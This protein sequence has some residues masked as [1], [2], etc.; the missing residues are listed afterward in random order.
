MC[1]EGSEQRADTDSGSAEVVDLIDLQA[2]INLAASGQNLIN[3]ISGN[4]V[5]TA[6]ERVQLNQVKIVACLYIV[7]SCIQTG[8]VHPLVIDTER[9]LERCQMGNRVLRQHAQ[10]VG[11]D[12]IRDTVMD[13]RIDVVRTAGKHDAS[14]AGFFHI[15]KRFL[16]FFLHIASCSAK[17]FPSG[18]NSSTDFIL[19]QTGELFDKT[20]GKH[21]FTRKRKERIAERNG[22]V[23]QLVHVVFDIF[24]IRGNDWAVVVVDGFRELGA[25]VRDTR[26]EDELHT[27]A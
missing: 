4:G 1:T 25:L 22:I 10:S 17:L 19:R 2:G 11:V 5:E 8:V 6:A 23:L 16:A 24:R 7:C 21:L 9:T 15:L 18:M 26:V 27:V 14:A 20:I 12:H 3:L 13:F